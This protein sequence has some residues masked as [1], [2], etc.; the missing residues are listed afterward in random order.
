[1]WPLNFRWVKNGYHQ[2]FKYSMVSIYFFHKIGNAGVKFYAWQIAMSKK[3]FFS[4]SLMERPYYTLNGILHCT[5]GEKAFFKSFFLLLKI[6]E[7]TGFH[8]GCGSVKTRIFVDF[9][10]YLLHKF[11]SHTSKNKISWYMP[12]CGLFIFFEILVEF[13]RFPEYLY[14]NPTIFLFLIKSLTW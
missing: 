8:W 11:I 2:D 3:K 12:C 5:L 6:Y 9:L 1:M 13:K 7:N 10:Q 14:Y 4:I